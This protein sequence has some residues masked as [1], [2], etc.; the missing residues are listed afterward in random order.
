MRVKQSRIQTYH[1]R[2]AN[3]KKD[4]EGGTYVEYGEP[5]SFHAVIWQA[6]GKLQAEIY[7]QRLNYIRNCKVEGK[8]S[9]VPDGKKLNYVFDSELIFCEGDGICVYAP[10]QSDPDY[11][12]IS[13]KPNLTLYMELEKI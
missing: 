10:A 3:N 4:S 12:I 2:Q 13:I 8:Y 7:G 6:S 11:R 9:I 5:S 1:L